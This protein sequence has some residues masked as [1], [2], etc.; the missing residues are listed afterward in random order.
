MI[1]RRKFLIS[2]P[3]AVKRQFPKKFQI[4]LLKAVDQKFSLVRMSVQSGCFNKGCRVGWG[5]KEGGRGKEACSQLNLDYRCIMSQLEECS[6]VKLC[7]QNTQCSYIL[8][9]KE[10]PISGHYWARA[11]NER[12]LIAYVEKPGLTKK[13]ATVSACSLDVFLCPLSDK[14]EI[15]KKMDN[16]SVKYR[17]HKHINLPRQEI[18]FQFLPPSVPRRILHC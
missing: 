12:D 10:S 1:S 14:V 4:L 9:N 18:D 5:G 17:T 2:W 6:L 11:L 7:Q 8:Y 3:F 15:C 16:T 13:V